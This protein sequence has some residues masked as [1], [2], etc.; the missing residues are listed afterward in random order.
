MF[1]L[2]VNVTTKKHTNLHIHMSQISS[3]IKRKLKKKISNESINMATIKSVTQ[4]SELQIDKFEI[5]LQTESASVFDTFKTN[6]VAWFTK[7]FDDYLVDE[8]RYFPNIQ[9]DEV[10]VA[11]QEETPLQLLEKAQQQEIAELTRQLQS[12]QLL[13]LTQLKESHEQQ[14]KELII[15]LTQE[16]AAQCAELSDN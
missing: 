8:R 2:R 14:M 10:T 6:V 9:E 12:A 4:Y 3:D 15:R 13:E 11:L 16:H 5:V 7:I 1:F